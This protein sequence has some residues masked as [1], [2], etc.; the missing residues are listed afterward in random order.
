MIYNQE[1]NFGQ[2]ETL[3]LII[4]QLIVRPKSITCSQVLKATYIPS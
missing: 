2:P 1:N 3:T 4:V